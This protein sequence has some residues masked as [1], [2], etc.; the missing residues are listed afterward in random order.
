MIDADGE[1]QDTA[2]RS[3]SSTGPQD[4]FHAGY[5]AGLTRT[6]LKDVDG[7]ITH[8]RL[9][10]GSG[11]PGDIGESPEIGGGCAA[12]IM[13]TENFL[14]TALSDD[15]VNFDFFADDMTIA[16][17]Y[18]PGQVGCAYA[19]AASST[20]K[21]DAIHG[22]LTVGKNPNTNR[23]FYVIKGYL[24]ATAGTGESLISVA[25]ENFDLVCEARFN[26]GTSKT[27]FN[28]VTTGVV[29]DNLGNIYTN[30]T[31]IG[32]YG[33]K[34]T[35][36]VKIDPLTCATT[37]LV[38][39]NAAANGSTV[40]SGLTLGAT[41]ENEAVLLGAAAGNLYIKNLTTGTLTT[42]P[43]AS[44]S[45]DTVIGAP[46]IDAAGRV[47]VMSKSNVMTIFNTLNLNYG[48]HFW[49]RFRK[50]NFG[51]ATVEITIE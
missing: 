51:S 21:S 45:T 42:Q 48:D 5:T 49:P 7:N 39:L 35:K 15:L 32:S 43:L 36:M 24:P 22:E 17:S 44:G 12:Y 40:F 9:A 20:M 3:D 10:F 31:T 2:V 14:N 16:K 30:A 27:P 11:Q 37:N 8:D 4:E 46:V 34:Y 33:V 38:E 25:D 23:P 50:D 28:S 6:I 19:N 41:A 1:L 26:A 13:D 18:D 29:V 47:I